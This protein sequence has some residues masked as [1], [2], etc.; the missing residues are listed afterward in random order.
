MPGDGNWAG[1]L[2]LQSRLNYRGDQQPVFT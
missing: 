2:N 1:L